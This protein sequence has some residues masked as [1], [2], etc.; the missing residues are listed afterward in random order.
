NAIKSKSSGRGSF[1]TFFGARPNSFSSV[2]NFANND[3][4]VSPPFGVSAAT[5][6]KNIG[7]PGGQSTG[8]VSKNEDLA[9]GPADNSRSR[10]IARVSTLRESPRFDPKA[11]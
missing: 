9:I 1:R 8:V 4:G 2:C 6:F 11:M 7:D 10:S 5:A 3:S